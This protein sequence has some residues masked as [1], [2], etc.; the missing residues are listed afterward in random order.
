MLSAIGYFVLTPCAA[1]ADQAQPVL[2]EAGITQDDNVTRAKSSSDRRGDTVYNVNLSKVFALLPLSDQSRLV[3]TGALA[4][5]KYS[6]HKRLSHIGLSVDA[7]FQYRNSSE[8]FDPTWSAFAKWTLQSYDAS[9]RDGNQ[10]AVG[11]SVQQA[12]TDRISVVGALT[13]N[14]RGADSAVFETRDNSLGVSIDYALTDAS[15]LYLGGDYRRGDII[16]GGRRSLE[17]VRIAKAYAVDDAFAVSA[18]PFYSYRIDGRTALLTLGYNLDLGT[19]GALD[20]SWRFARATPSSRRDWVTSARNYKT[21][22]VSVVYLLR[23]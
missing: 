23:F 15:T 3:L 5:E 1:V 17:S 21:N 12:L 6:K 4:G 22:Q 10:L 14:R 19:R 9:M 18:D 8:F 2:L 7:K 20:L 16:S 11:L 13:H